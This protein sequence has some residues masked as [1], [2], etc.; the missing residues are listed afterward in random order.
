[1][2]NLFVESPALRAQLFGALDR[3]TKS[4]NKS[5]QDAPT[6][7]PKFAAPSIAPDV[8]A[9]LMEAHSAL[10][11]AFALVAAVALAGVAEYFSVAGMTEVFPGLR[12]PSWHSRRVWKLRSSS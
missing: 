5:R 11:N 3:A 12:S 9:P 6:A 2:E 1:M 7:L 8:V 4:A 10:S